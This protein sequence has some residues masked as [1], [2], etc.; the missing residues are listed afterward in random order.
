MRSSKDK[1]RYGIDTVKEAKDWF[2]KNGIELYGFNDNP[3]Q[4]EWSDSRKI[5]AHAYIDDQFLGVPLTYYKYFGERFF[6][7]W[8]LI[9]S[10]LS[11]DG[12]IT[13][14]QYLEIKDKLM[15]EYPDIY[16]KHS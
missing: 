7:D 16:K 5:Y 8:Y 14:Q 4:H 11:Q 12:F 1:E 9:A 10:L 6:V 13:P 3:S 2:N 15:K